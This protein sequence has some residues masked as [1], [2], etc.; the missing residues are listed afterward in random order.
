[1]CIQPQ[2][3]PY[4]RPCLFGQLHHVVVEVV[5][6]FGVQRLGPAAYGRIMGTC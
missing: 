4:D 1:M 5:Q 6:R 2:L 3:V